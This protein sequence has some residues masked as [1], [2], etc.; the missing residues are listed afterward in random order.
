[1]NL[2]VF[3]CYK[4]KISS[5]YVGLILFF[6]VLMVGV[7]PVFGEIVI[8]EWVYKIHQYWKDY[9]ITRDEF[10]NA[11]SY[12]QEINTI[13]LE[14]ETSP[15]A[16]FLLSDSLLKQERL[17]HSEFSNCS[18]EWYI[19]GYF[20]PVE[21]DY[22]GKFIDVII[23]GK[24][25]KYRESFVT[26]I[27][28]EGWGRTISGNYLGWYGNSF[29]LSDKPLD[30]EGNTL[31]LNAIAIDT[32]VIPVNSNLTI[33]SLPSPWD[34]SIFTGSDIGTAIVGKHIDVYTGEGKTAHDETFRITGNDNVVCLGEG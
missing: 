7:L 25:Y 15:I 23:D 2:H 1:M 27:K 17:G 5:M 29:H 6:G 9:Q 26:E 3:L 21:S 31:T 4:A 24:Q 34:E 33:P 18:A 13:Q 28:T 32:S 10:S 22:S 16:S 19:T 12:L 14:E 8:P 20:T 11:I 30:S